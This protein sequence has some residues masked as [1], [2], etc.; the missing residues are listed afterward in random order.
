[1]EDLEAL[2]NR[3]F[4]SWKSMHENLQTAAHSA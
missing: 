3:D 1:V 2:L 4:S